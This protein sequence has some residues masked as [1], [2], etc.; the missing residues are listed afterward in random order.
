MVHAIL[1][2]IDKVVDEINVE[3]RLQQNAALCLSQIMV[4]RVINK[5]N[6]TLCWVHTHMDKGKMIERPGYIAP[7]CSKNGSV[8][9][10][11]MKGAFT[12]QWGN[13]RE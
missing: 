1:I 12:Y 2:N 4:F 9:E 13:S 6:K 5:T 7:G 11:D 3:A 8:V 10:D